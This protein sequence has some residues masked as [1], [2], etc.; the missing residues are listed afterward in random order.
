MK[1]DSYFVSQFSNEFALMGQLCRSS[2][3]KGEVDLIISMSGVLVEKKIGALVDLVIEAGNKIVNVNKWYRTLTLNCDDSKFEP[4]KS[5]GDDTFSYLDLINGHVIA[6]IRGNWN[7]KYK[8][9]ITFKFKVTIQWRQYESEEDIYFP[10][11]TPTYIIN[12]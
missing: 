1:K 8:D 7:A 5:Q 11:N 4:N 10:D 9:L 6:V 12:L 3:K 2:N